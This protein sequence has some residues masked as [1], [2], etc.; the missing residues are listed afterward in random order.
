MHMKGFYFKV[1][2]IITVIYVHVTLGAIGQISLDS[3]MSNL[4]DVL[5]IDSTR[6]E[7]RERA[8]DLLRMAYEAQSDSLIA[9]A[10]AMLSAWYDYYNY[11]A[12]GPSGDSVIYHESKAQEIYHK[13]GRG[14]DAATSDRYISLA[15]ANM[16]NYVKAEKHALNALHY[17]ESINDERNIGLAF[18][19]LCSLYSSMDDY[20]KT[21]EYGLKSNEILENYKDEISALC[22]NIFSM[23]RAYA[24]LD[25]YREGIALA[26]RGLMMMEEN[27]M[28]DEIGL[29]VRII[30]SRGYAFEQ[31]EEYDRALENYTEAWQLVHKEV[32]G[33]HTRSDSWRDDIGNMLMKKG[34][35]QLALPHLKAAVIAYENHM[36]NRLY[37]SYDELKTC[38]EKLGDFEN[39][40]VYS[41]KVRMSRDSMYQ[42]KVATLE[43]EGMIKYE[44]GKKDEALAMQNI[45]LEQQRKIQ[46][47]SFGGLGLLL[48][49]LGGLYYNYRKNQQFAN[50]LKHLNGDLRLRNQENELLL[51]EIHHRVKNN[52]QVISSLLNFQSRS[53]VDKNAKS[54]ILDSQSR[55]RSM[56]LIHQ[57]LYRG[58]NLASIEMKNYLDVLSE[59][60]VESYSDEDLIDIKINME[61]I[62]LDVDYAVPIGLI[63]NELVTN[64]LKYA[65]PKGERGTIEIELKR[66]N[67]ELVLYISDS[68]IGK[69]SQGQHSVDGGF[70]TELIEML[71]IQLK[72]E[73][74]QEADN[75][76]RT[77]LTIPLAK[78]A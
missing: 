25:Q 59:S 9:E 63:T 15:Y 12:E 52:L 47:L 19:R 73:L 49:L 34:N 51:K 28:M 3:M 24:N 16:Q 29:L 32:G 43:T 72:G 64:S 54:A 2:F 78:A 50:E 39:A 38:Y 10:H 77:R 48:L 45:Q 17:F 44:T 13:Q 46:L 36:S 57:K 74:K 67:D 27:E 42:E 4:N 55:V 18:K 5:F 26:D 75:G 14:E 23:V 11:N 71:T 61:E 7:S 6:M 56:S 66:N 21:I 76:Y 35:Y 70:G 31:M 62:E 22:I 60:L 68:G 8:Y 1:S 53:I 41:E 65:F 33:D 69:D 37:E 30:S 40:Y 20:E 58:S